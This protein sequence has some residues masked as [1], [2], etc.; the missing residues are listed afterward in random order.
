MFE[1]LPLPS[2]RASTEARKE[3]G[4]PILEDPAPARYG[5]SSASLQ[6]EG[7]VL[8]I[9][10]QPL[11]IEMLAVPIT[12]IRARICCLRET[13]RSRYDIEAS[14]RTRRAAGSL[15]AFKRPMRSQAFFNNIPRSFQ[16]SARP[17]QDVRS[18]TSNSTRLWTHSS[19]RHLFF[20]SGEVCVR[21]P[22]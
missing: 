18:H 6:S 15:D 16:C 4:D 10:V 12:L 5:F 9:K 20:A 19:A 14:R 22:A 2:L 3:L 7:D 8:S 13:H 11:E 21:G 17:R 1:K